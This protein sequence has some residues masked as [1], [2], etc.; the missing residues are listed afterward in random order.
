MPNF[1][2]MKKLFI[3]T[4]AIITA[5]A[6]CKSS[7]NNSDFAS[8]DF[9][10]T[11]VKTEVVYYDNPPAEGFNAEESSPF[12]VIL[13]DQVMN[14]MGGR[15]AWDDTN[16][17]YWNF[18]GAR[19]LL[20]DKENNRVRIDMPKNEM[21]MTL[22]MDDMSGKVWKSG[23]EMQSPDSLTKYLDRAKRIWIN[24][25]YWLVMPF[26]LKDSG[27]TLTYVGEDTTQ[28]GVKADLV[29]LT[30]EGVGVTPQNAYN[31][32]I[33]YDNKLIQQWAYFS[34]ATNE[35]PNFVLPW[36]DYEKYGDIML[37]GERGD[38]D[39]TDIKVLKKAPK[40][41]FE[42]PEPIKF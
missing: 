24:D 14:S 12:A 22:N 11:N 29:R 32:W 34:D 36:T 15:K 7:S 33:D 25:S 10:D 16:V 27:V 18:F 35:E 39:L 3:P 42:S 40:G 37:S 13:A 26:K 8:D 5:L 38:R 41:A 1:N 30:F 31:V 17:L 9:G 6:S 20:W 2:T 19:T 28:T 4:L 21:V 23:E